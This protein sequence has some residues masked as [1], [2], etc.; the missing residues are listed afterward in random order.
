MAETQASRMV[1]RR[2]FCGR[3]GERGENQKVAGFNAT[4]VKVGGDPCECS[5]HS[6]NG[7]V[8]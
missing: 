5:G 2:M 3:A 7:L 6:A 1:C 4:H 8:E